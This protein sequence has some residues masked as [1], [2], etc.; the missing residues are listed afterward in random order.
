MYQYLMQKVKCEYERNIFDL[1]V[2]YFKRIC[3]KVY[4][5]KV[6][7][8]KVIFQSK[9]RKYFCEYNKST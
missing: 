6:F 1:K 2:K 7:D 9:I 8:M 4:T 3:L 5:S